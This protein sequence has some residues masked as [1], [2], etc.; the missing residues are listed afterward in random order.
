MRPSSRSAAR[1]HSIGEGDE[2]CLAGLVLRRNP[3]GERQQRVL[4]RMSAN[5]AGGSFPV[6]RRAPKLREMNSGHPFCPAAEPARGRSPHPVP[7]CRH[8]CMAPRLLSG[9]ACLA[10]EP[11]ATQRFPPAG[12]GEPSCSQSAGCLPQPGVHQFRQD[13]AFKGRRYSKHAHTTYVSTTIN[14]CPRGG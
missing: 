1:C 13:K 4:S 12:G 9:T 6:T 3:L 5:W 2:V 10:V 8:S 7:R 11:T 14:V